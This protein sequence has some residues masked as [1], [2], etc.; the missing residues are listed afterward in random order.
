MAPPS[1]VRPLAM[2][3]HP[4]RHDHHAIGEVAGVVVPDSHL[5]RQ[6]TELVRDTEDDLL[7]HH[8][9]RVF[10]FAALTG[11]GKALKYDPEL[12]YAAAMFHDMG[13]VPAYS[14]KDKRFEVDGANL[15]RDF[16]RRHGVAEDDIYTVWT[17]IALHTTPNIPEFMKPEVALLTAGVEMDVLGMGFRNVADADRLEVARRHPR[18]PDFKEGIIDHFYQGIRNKPETTFGNV[19][20]DVMAYKEPKT[21]QRMDFCRLILGNP[22][23]R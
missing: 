15:A 19:K 18:E 13:L 14:S 7:Y 12:L 11:D 22:W 4:H 20:A 6:I 23:P 8:S 16:L 17:S 9:R 5:A 10:F 21:F 1:S 2:N 3:A